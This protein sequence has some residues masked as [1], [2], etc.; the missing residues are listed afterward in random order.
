MHL[1]QFFA[2]SFLFQKEPTEAKY[3]AQSMNLELCPEPLEIGLRLQRQRT[4]VDCM[5]KMAIQRTLQQSE[6]LTAV[7][8]YFKKALS[9]IVSNSAPGSN[10]TD[11]MFS[12]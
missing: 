3:S 10:E 1:C 11:T 4:Q 9:S 7:K 2:P 6:N 12:H 8:P 5:R